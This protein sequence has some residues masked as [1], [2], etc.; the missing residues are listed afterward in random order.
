MD[1]GARRGVANSTFIL[2]GD[3]G[4][5]LG[6]F[7]WGIASDFGGYAFAY[8]FAGLTML[9]GMGLHL[10]WLRPHL[11]AADDVSAASSGQTSPCAAQWER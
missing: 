7:V 9:S 3:I 2:F 8:L 5:G 10:L 11:V 1:S 6:A 4:N